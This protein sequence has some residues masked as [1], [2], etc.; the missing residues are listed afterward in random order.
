MELAIGTDGAAQFLCDD[1]ELE[2]AQAHAAEFLGDGGAQ[3]AH[4]AQAL[5]QRL[6]VGLGPLQDHAYG[7]GRTAVGQEAPGLL[8]QLLLLV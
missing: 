2:V 5:P 7:G 3:E 6:V 4:L 8:A 1:A